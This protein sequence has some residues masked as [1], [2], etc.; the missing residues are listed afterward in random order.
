MTC[1]HNHTNEND[2]QNEL[3]ICPRCGKLGLLG[4]GDGVC[5]ACESKA[6]EDALAGSDDDETEAE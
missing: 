3:E 1:E 5:E 4:D 2:S 6:I